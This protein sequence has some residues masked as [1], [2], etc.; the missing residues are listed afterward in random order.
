VKNKSIL[1]TLL[2]CLVLPNS[3]FAGGVGSCPSTYSNWST[4][5]HDAA[6]YTSYKIKAPVEVF[7]G[8]PFDVTA[9]VTD[10][11]FPNNWVGGPWAIFDTYSASS[12]KVKN[13]LMQG[14]VNNEPGNIWTQNGQWQRIITQT[15][16]GTP[17]DHKLEFSFKDMGTSAFSSTSGM[18]WTGGIIGNITLDPFLITVT[19]NV[20]FRTDQQSS[21]VISATIFNPS[22]TVLAYRWFEGATVLQ[23]SLPLDGSDNAPLNLASLSP[24]SAGTHTFTLEV[25][26]GTSIATAPVAVLV[27]P[28]L[29]SG[30][31]TAVPIMEGWWLL[32][33]VLAGF[34][35]YARR[36]KE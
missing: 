31:V 33:G 21:T 29:N 18:S 20:T 28:P 27:T 24:L 16:S 23:A 11:R 13:T 3:A 15:Y 34:G 14:S 36:R 22:G 4:S 19:P 7:I 2:C 32:P 5:W 12:G 6:N 30:T 17:Y 35:M 10:N 9:T 26:D 8:C 25:T 1:Y